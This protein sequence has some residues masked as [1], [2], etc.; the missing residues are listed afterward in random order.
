M[1]LNFKVK[2]LQKLVSCYRASD[3]QALHSLNDTSVSPGND[4]LAS[5]P[6]LN[7]ILLPTSTVTPVNSFPPLLISK[8]LPYQ[9][10]LINK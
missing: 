10:N 8:L 6:S 2:R 5:T 7:Y 3:S 1:V 9:N 4:S